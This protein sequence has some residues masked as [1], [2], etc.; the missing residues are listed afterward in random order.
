M[1]FELTFEDADQVSK[2]SDWDVVSIRFLKS[3]LFRAKKDFKSF[4]K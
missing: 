1:T 4:E 3:S 2:S